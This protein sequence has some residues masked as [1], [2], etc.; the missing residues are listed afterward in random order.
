MSEIWKFCFGL[1]TRI[2]MN[3]FPCPN[4]QNFILDTK[5]ELNEIGFRALNS[6]ILFWTQNPNFNKSV[7]VP[8]I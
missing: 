4:F 1:E 7:L 2:Y 3:R 6:L 5:L 8:K